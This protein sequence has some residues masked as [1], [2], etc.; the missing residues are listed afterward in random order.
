M[1]KLLLLCTTALVG[2]SCSAFAEDVTVSF[3]GSSTFEAG[4]RKVDKNHKAAFSYSPNQKSATFFTEQQATIKAEGKADAL[5]Y[6]AILNLQMVGNSDTGAGDFKNNRSYIYLDTDAGAVQLGSNAAVSKMLKIDAGTI[7]SA[8]GGVDGDW[9]NFTNIATINT[10]NY[11]NG[12]QV[13]NL[14]WNGVTAGNMGDSLAITG[15]D[16]LSNRLDAG[17]STRKITY[18]S[19]RISGLQLGVSFAPDINNTG[20]NN[21]LTSSN[22]NGTLFS[23]MYLGAPVRVTNHWSLGLNYTNIFNDITLGLSAVADKG[24]AKNQTV[25]YTDINSMDQATTLSFRDLKTYAIGGSVA[26]HGFTLAS[27]YQN[28]G[29]SLTLTSQDKFKASWWTV[30]LAYGQDKW[31][32]SLSYLS[33]KKGTDTQNLKTTLVSLGAD[34]ELVPGMTTFAEVTRV[35]MKPKSLDASDSRT[36]GTVFILGTR[37]KF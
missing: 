20:Q 22:P 29:K 10:T 2:L 37:I 23:N 7:A 24:K 19:P 21:L 31:S 16:T 8:T 5:T 18:L 15:V 12:S 33:G 9:G 35:Q 1:K 32:T 14:T 13:T 25:S 27:S 6:G 28:D 36:K 17:E 11:I 34:Y 3:S 26:T 4:A 30:G